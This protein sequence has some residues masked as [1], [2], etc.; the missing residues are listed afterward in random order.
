MAGATFQKPVYGREQKHTLSPITDFDPRPEQY[1][2]TAP[3]LLQEF[4][5]K[6]KGEGLVVSL[7]KDVD[8]EYAKRMKPVVL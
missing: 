2:G 7:L 5:E 1:R 8:T 4:L 6:V 3:T